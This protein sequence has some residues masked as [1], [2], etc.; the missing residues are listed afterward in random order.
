MINAEILS[1][2][3]E[4]IFSLYNTYKKQPKV[5]AVIFGKYPLLEQLLSAAHAHI[6]LT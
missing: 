1:V 3:C 6:T 2:G 4:H 5:G